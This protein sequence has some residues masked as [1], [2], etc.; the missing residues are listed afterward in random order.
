MADPAT[1]DNRPFARRAQVDEDVRRLVA[2][3]RLADDHIWCEC[4]LQ[5]PPHE[6]IL[7]KPH[8][9]LRAALEP[10]KATTVE[11]GRSDA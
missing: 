7:C 4:V 8:K 6:D 10:F 2:A 9:A 1:V 3:A 11:E 5:P